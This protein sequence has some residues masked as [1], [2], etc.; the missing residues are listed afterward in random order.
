MKNTDWKNHALMAA[1]IAI[2]LMAV[3]CGR[4]ETHSAV[5]AATGGE[6]GVTRMATS[7]TGGPRGE[8][9]AG[10]ALTAATPEAGLSGDEAIGGEAAETPTSGAGASNH[11]DSEPPDVIAS[12]ADSLV[13]PGGVVEVTAEASPDVVQVTLNDGIGKPKPLVYDAGAGLWRTTYRV[14]LKAGTQRVGFSITARNGREQWRRVWVFPS[15]PREEASRQ[16][17]VGE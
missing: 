7:Q 10:V 8:A 15:A 17:D 12:I 4:E 6:K 9:V 5:G 16:G 13:V 2:V 14:P 3:G 1:S 11:A